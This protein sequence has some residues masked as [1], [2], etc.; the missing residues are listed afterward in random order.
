[1]VDTTNLSANSNPPGCMHSKPKKK[2]KITL[3]YLLFFLGIYLVNCLNV[4]CALVIDLALNVF[5]SSW[6]YS[7]SPVK[8]RQRYDCSWGRSW[9]CDVYSRVYLSKTITTINTVP[10]TITTIESV[11]KSPKKQTHKHVT[12]REYEWI[13]CNNKKLIL[14][15]W[16]I[17]CSA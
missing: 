10:K 16:N 5:I 13:L 17:N 12:W 9:K 4:Y 11:P 14:R 3:R 2:K 1:M 7:D 8:R 15:S 6:T